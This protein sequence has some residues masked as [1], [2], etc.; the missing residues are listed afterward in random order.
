[1]IVSFEYQNNRTRHNFMTVDFEKFFPNTIR[2]TK[3]LFKFMVPNLDS[4]KIQEIEE[5]LAGKE[6][7]RYKRYLEI[8]R[9]VKK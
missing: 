6:D 3:K 2:R 7:K 5:W 9:E 4:Q 1:M 8:F